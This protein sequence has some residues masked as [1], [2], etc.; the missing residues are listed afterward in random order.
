MNRII[1][2]LLSL[3]PVPGSAAFCRLG[4]HSFLVKSG[5]VTIAFDPY[6]TADSN[7]L[8]APLITPEEFCHID[9]ICCSHDHGDH[10]DR[11]ALSAMA[12]ASPEAVFV[13]PQAVKES[14]TEI[15]SERILGMNDGECLCI[16]NITIHAVAAAHEM[17]DQTPEG[18]FPYLGYIASVNGISVYHS[19]DCCVYDGLLPK[20][21]ANLP[22]IMLLPINGRDAERFKRGCIGNMTYQEA[23]DLAGFTGIKIA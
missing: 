22:D 7:R 12:K 21:K 5:N 11:P 16:K 6:L 15:P 19:G 23:V 10:I 13:V 2:Q 1:E 20:L 8:I 17:L 9:V 4:Q 3:A 18:L 14:I